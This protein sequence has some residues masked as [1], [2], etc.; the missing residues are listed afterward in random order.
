MSTPVDSLDLASMR[1]HSGEGRRLTPEIR[2]GPIELGG[3]TYAVEPPLIPTQ[4]DLSKTS[5]DGYALR[6]R[7]TAALAGPCM[8]CLKAATAAFTVDS[9]EVSQPG[10]AAELDSPY[11][12][13]GLLD[14]AAWG[15]DALVLTLPA[16]ILCRSDC[17]GMCSVCGT[18]LNDAGPEHGHEAGP[19][20]RWAKLSEIRFDS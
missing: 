1:L 11:V 18:D 14:L 7:F 15:R 3:D 4:L 6:L 9:R 12:E 16:T 19:D 13:R 17:A 8:R 20:P 2:I 5:G 10:E